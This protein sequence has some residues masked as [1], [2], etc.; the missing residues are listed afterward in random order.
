VI[1]QDEL[2]ELGINVDF[3]A[4][5]FQLLLDETAGAQTFDAAIMG[6]RE[7]FPSDPDQLQLF[8]PSNDDPTNQG[9]NAGLTTTPSSSACRSR[10]LRCPAVLSPG[11]RRSITRS[12]S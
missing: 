12:R 2:Y 10:R 7:G 9:S 3:Q 6:W 1:I 5:D 8:S 11:A 4:I